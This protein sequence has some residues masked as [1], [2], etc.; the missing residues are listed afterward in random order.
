MSDPTLASLFMHSPL[1]W[2]LLTLVSYLAALW[3]YRRSGSNPLLIPVLTAVLVIVAVLLLTDT[4][5]PVYFEGVQPL[6]FLIG[7]ATVALAV[8]LYG[9]MGRIRQMWLPIGIALLVGSSVAIV[10][11]LG[12]AWA[13]GGEMETLLSL[14]PKSASM[15]FAMPVAER[16]GGLASLAAVAVAITGIA[17]TIM[18]RPLLN[19]MRVHD[20]AVRGFAVGLTAHAIGTAR[21]IQDNETAGAFAALAMGLNGI[22]TAVLVPV[23]VQ[24]MHAVV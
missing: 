21:E 11:A 8:P 20:P 15:P 5:Y 12:V 6:Y 16:L 19:L 7:P 9:Q 1:P 14:A 22:A 24:L 18:A 3:L 13:L 17:G 23:F 10:S 4:P 2:L